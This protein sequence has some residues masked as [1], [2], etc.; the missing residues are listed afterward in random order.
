MGSPQQLAPPLL[1]WF[2]K[3]RRLL[4]FRQEPTPYHIWVSEIML[5][6]TRMTAAVPYYQRFI[7]ALPDI[8]ALAACGEETLHKLWQGLGYYH[9]AANLHKAAQILCRE[10]GGNLPADYNALRALPGIGDY[11]AGAVASMGFGIPVAAVDGNVLR[12]FARLYN[13]GEDITLPATKRA[14]TAFVMAHQPPD[15]PGDYNQA[16]MELG[17]LIC[18]PNAAPLCAQCPLAAQCAG[19]ATGD[20]ARLLQLPV[21]PPKKQ[22]PVLPVAVLRVESPAGILLQKRPAKGLLAGLWQPPAW[23]DATLPE[24]EARRWLAGQGLAVV[25]MAPLPA[26][27]HIF[28]HKVW[29]LGGWR[30]Q[31]APAPAPEGFVWASPAALA[32][33][34]AVPSAFRFCL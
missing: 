8:P 3:N 25:A 30:C 20:A 9:R 6:Q 2:Y 7:A 12:V 31:V 14:F 1:T 28:T 5:Q 4:P 13:S 11:T 27:K 18:L 21:K 10:Y 15:A 26:G 33:Q 23:E 22:R 34:Y 17:A 19:Y 16:L 29:A 24:A 32:G